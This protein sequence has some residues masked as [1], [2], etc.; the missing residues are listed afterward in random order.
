MDTN[1]EKDCAVLE[2]FFQ[3]IIVDMKVIGDY[4]YNRSADLRCTLNT[5]TFIVVV[6]FLYCLN[7]QRFR[8]CE[9]KRYI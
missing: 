1:M 8:H 7:A 2:E 5:P 9:L 3:Q 4:V 6:V